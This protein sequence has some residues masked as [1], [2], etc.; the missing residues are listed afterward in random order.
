MLRTDVS[1][2]G[3]AEIIKETKKSELETTGNRST[4]TVWQDA[5]L[6]MLNMLNETAGFTI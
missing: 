3:I 1:E 2:E 5:G 4:Q 6:H